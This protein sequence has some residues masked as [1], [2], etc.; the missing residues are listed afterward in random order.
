MKAYLYILNNNVH[1]TPEFHTLVLTYSCKRFFLEPSN[2]PVISKAVTHNRT[3]TSARASNTTAAVGSGT[4]LALGTPEDSV[5]QNTDSF[6]TLNK[7][8]HTGSFH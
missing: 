1:I 4:S 6:L 5:I 2:T 8:Q 7:I 3:N